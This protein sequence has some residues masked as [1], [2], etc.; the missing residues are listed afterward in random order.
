MQRKN[1]S[2]LVMLST[3]HILP[4]AFPWIPLIN[5]PILSYSGRL[6]IS[7]RQKLH[8]ATLRTPRA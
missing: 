8:N 5:L 1:A 2:L 3:L 7:L 4:A 6:P